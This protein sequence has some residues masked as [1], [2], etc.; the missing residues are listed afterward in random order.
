MKTLKLL[1]TFIILSSVIAFSF[2]CSYAANGSFAANS[3][4][5]ANEAIDLGAKDVSAVSVRLSA[6]TGVYL[7]Q[8]AR[9]SSPQAPPSFLFGG[10]EPFDIQALYDYYSNYAL[11]FDDSAF[12][13]SM[14]PAAEASA[15]GGEL[16]AAPAELTEEQISERILEL[17]EAYINELKELNE[18]NEQ[19]ENADDEKSS[20]AAAANTGGDAANAGEKA[21]DGAGAAPEESVL[22][23]ISVTSPNIEDKE[24]VYKDTYSICGVRDDDADPDELIILYLTRYD[25]ETEAYDEF[26]DISGESRWTVGTNGVFTRS[27]LLD[28]GENRFAI[29]ACEAGIIEAAM[30]EGRIIEERDIQIVMFNI[31]YRAQSMAEKIG[32]IIK[33]LT[34]A[35]ILKEIGNN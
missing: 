32:E 10:G 23:L 27:V 21:E 5:A 16:P 9:V 33:E 15:A 8:A 28:E 1:L 34:L 6:L 25:V 18:L 24:I 2:F 13:D 17:I 3:S 14:T 30:L 31:T 29:A 20:G 26:S 35:N 4:F 11:F 19:I 12:F 7:V 22:V